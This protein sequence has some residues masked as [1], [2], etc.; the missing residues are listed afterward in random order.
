MAASKYHIEVNLVG[1]YRHYWGTT[2]HTVVPHA[3]VTTAVFLPANRELPPPFRTLH[4]ELSTLGLGPNVEVRRGRGRQ[5][6]SIR[7]LLPS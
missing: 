4:S 2:L 1:T 3:A 7:I 5:E 6:V